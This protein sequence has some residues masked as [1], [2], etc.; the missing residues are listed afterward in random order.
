MKR[1]Q[2]FLAPTLWCAL[3]GFRWVKVFVGF[4]LIVVDAFIRCDT[5][6]EVFGLLK[7][8]RFWPVIVAILGDEYRFPSCGAVAVRVRCGLAEV[9]SRLNIFTNVAFVRIQRSVSHIDTSSANTTARSRSR[10]SSL[11]HTID[12]RDLRYVVRNESPF[13]TF[14]QRI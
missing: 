9:S 3:D 13:T 2:I 12:W 1:P 4:N 5:F 14:I 11:I 7:T 8:K 10:Q 6:D